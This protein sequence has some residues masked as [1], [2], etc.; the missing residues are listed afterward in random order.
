MCSSDL[1]A[2]RRTSA[3][4]HAVVRARRTD[5]ETLDELLAQELRR[6]PWF[7]LS[8][9][10]HGLLLLLLWWW[11]PTR[12]VGGDAPASVNIQLAGE[13][14]QSGP[15][16]TVPEVQSEA[17]PVA[18]EPPAQEPNPQPD[19]PQL[20]AIDGPEPRP[21]PDPALAQVRIGAPSRTASDG[22]GL[23]EI[24]RAHV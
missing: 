23:G 11:L 3:A 18:F 14:P 10:A 1:A 21:R 8:L 17:E 20:P 6:A 13:L 22:R 5:G 16:A 12:T 9:V 24:G 19:A 7:T 4:A 15:A 2:V